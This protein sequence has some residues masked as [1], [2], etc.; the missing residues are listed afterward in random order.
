[1]LTSQLFDVLTFAA[2]RHQYQRRGGYDKLPYINHLVK[3]ANILIQVG[4]ETDEVTLKAAILHDILEDG[5]A[6]K[7][8][9]AEK[10]GEEVC[11]IVLELTDDMAL[12]YEERKRIQ[13]AKAGEL[14]LPA[15]KIKIADKSCNIRDIVDYPLSWDDSRKLAYIEWS[16]EVVYKLSESLPALKNYF[17][18]CV[19]YGLKKLEKI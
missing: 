7:E 9:L 18:A 1:M 12:D 5:H 6:T 17:E 16:Q 15:Q 4:K 2:I 19:Q 8:E 14:S 3:V 10:F 11:N 13:V